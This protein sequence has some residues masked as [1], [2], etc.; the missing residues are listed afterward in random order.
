LIGKTLSHYRIVEKIGAGGMGEVYRAHD[1]RLERDVALKVLPQGTLANETARKRFRKEALA[2]SKLNHPNVQTVFD[3]DTQDGMDFLVT[4]YVPGLTL[5]EKLG[6]GPLPENEI[7]RLG[8]QLAEGLAAAQKEHIVHRDIKPGN[9]RLTEDGRLK[10]LDFGLARLA[11]PVS[12]EAIT[13]S[14]TAPDAV[15]GTLPYMAP[16]QLR[17]EEVDS[18]SDIYAAGVVLYEMA[19]GQRPFKQKLSTALTDAIIHQAPEP[20]STQNRR[21][22]PGLESVILKA[23]EKEPE[24]RYQSAKELVVDLRR[25]GTASAAWAV[26]RPRRLPLRYLLAG[27]ATLVVLAVLLPLVPSWFEPLKDRLG[28]GPAAQPKHLVVLPFHPVSPGSAPFCDGLTETLTAKLT[29]LTA[30]HALQVVPASDVRK[31]GVASA[32]DAHKEFGAGLVME[33]TI[34]RHG[35]TVRVNYALVDT[36][37]LRQ[38]RAG[39]ITGEVSDPFAFQDG[40]VDRVVQLLDLELG[41]GERQALATPGTRVAGAYDFYLQGRGYLQN[42]DK[43][44]NIEHALTVFGQALELDPD[45]ALAHA[46][47]GEAYWLKYESSK[48]TRWVEKAHQACERALGL[49]AD[50]A[51]ARILLGTL[52]N[53]TGQYEEAVAEFQRALASEPTN[54]DAYRGLAHAY[55]RL[56]KP[57]EAERT[58]RRAIELRP[59]YWGG[60]NWLGAFYFRQARYPEAVEMFTQ[61][62]ALVPDSFRGYSSLGG[63][64]ILQGRYA[65]AITMLERSVTVRP[66]P[67]AYSNLASA[68]F[69]L[70]QFD[71]AARSY[72]EAVKL[73]ERDYVMWGNLA[74]AYYWAP[75]RR[76]QAPDAFHKAIAL[77]Q[78]KLRVNPREVYLLVDLAFY[79]A[80]L[81][82]RQPALDYLNRAHQLAP[83]DPDVRFKAALVHNQLGEI[84]L[85][86][87]WL[88]KAL[89]AG[90]APNI[91]RDSPVFDSLRDDPRFPELGPAT[92]DKPS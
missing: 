49:D 20:P 70:R 33:G 7:A 5:S 85:A 31:Q 24:N 89:E 69:Y 82:E 75:A 13:Q 90:V 19:T 36:I 46:G 66:T 84:E 42:Y 52:Q 91:V 11:Q 6:A 30:T 59:H 28:F 44:E 62:V 21:L 45:Y 58:Y 34:Y 80:M 8:A 47:L 92:T 39:T 86:L 88:E 71:Q 35:G 40:V 68:Y 43:P 83:A 72:E 79:H 25:V 74:E 22:S 12:E 29:Q 81:G 56:G 67:A 87:S 53:G 2:L 48:D 3:F 54:D 61:L 50:L 65:E 60:Y 14:L 27:V 16:E 37:T 38:L 76:A 4:E 73:N 18:R 64:F 15:A 10:I 1:E 17:G 23:L 9:L 26:A 41:P 77:A 55:E 63:L 78:E 51:T 57:E 32:S